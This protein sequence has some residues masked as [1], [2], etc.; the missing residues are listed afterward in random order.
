M[1]A[2]RIIVIGAGP[3][4]L[5]AAAYLAK[6][7]RRVCVLEARD[8]VGGMAGAVEFHPGY[9]ASGPLQHS[10]PLRPAV[11]RELELE[12]Y[13]LDLRSEPP[14]TWVLGA[15]GLP[16]RLGGN[17]GAAAESI[18]G[19]SAADAAAYGRYRA[20]LES[21]RA[22]LAGF[23]DR[24]PPQWI[25]PSGA[26]ALELARRGLEIRRLGRRRMTEF[27]RLPSMTVADWL[28]EW[29][30]SDALKGAL[31]IPAIAGT[32]MGPRSPGSN[33]NLLLHEA[34]A[35]P[36]VAG[37]GPALVMALE[38][39]ARDHGAEIRTAAPV[40]TILVDSGAVRG[41]RLDDGSEVEA[42]AV[43]AA[44]DPKQALLQ[45][46]PPGTL[47]FRVDEQI[48]AFRSRGT[49]AL[50]WLALDRPPRFSCAPNEPVEFARAGGGLDPL[51]RAFDAVKYG[52]FAE[53]PALE[54][55]QPTIAAPGMAPP[56][57]AVL[58]VL[59]HFAPHAP[60]E[61]WNDAL[62]DQLGERV[63]CQLEEYAPGLRATVVG[64]RVLSPADLESVY[65]ATG[66]HLHHGEHALDQLLVRPLP[67]CVGYRTPVRGL[68]LCGS[69]SHPGG[70]LTCGPGRLAAR[71]ILEA[72]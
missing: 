27:L 44:C 61:G 4:G 42:G 43:A 68:F 6:G 55:H 51:E 15:G 70:G 17:P 49:T 34:A 12:Q 63:L 20:M 41:V 67:D 11:A 66:G 47:P 1:S 39:C 54:V 53:R 23:L 57:H 37:D 22:P 45:L 69:G 26:Q 30:D 52:T 5:A 9:S 14:T 48:S 16:L 18:A 21:I 7:G 38:R 31:A 50:L 8:G 29:F 13:G 62:R 35:G 59:V 25:D 3:N 56:G 36:G 33:F 71:A 24:P 58:S 19:H 46:V 64:R 2:G 60:R 32:F 72:S 28:G 10:G 65:G 40:R